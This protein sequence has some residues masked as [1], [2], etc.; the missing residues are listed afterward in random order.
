MKTNIIK[1]L[2]FSLVFVSCQDMFEP[3]NDNHSTYERVLR[4]PTFAEGL[5]MTAYSK[6]PTNGLSFNE[7]A[8]DDAVTNDKLSSY[9]RMATGE[10]SALFNPVNEWDRCNSAVMYL[11][12]F[13]NVIDSVVWKWTDNELNMLYSKRFYGEAYALKGLFRY[14]L[15][16][17]VGGKDAAGNLLGIPL[18]EDKSNFN[19][20]RASFEE[21]VKQ[22]YADF[23]KALGYLTMD[24]Y[25]NV[26][27]QDELPAGFSGVNITNYNEVFGIR[28]NQRI[29]GRIV[30]ALKARVAL[31]AASPAFSNNNP[32]LWE[33]TANLSGVVLQS[34]GGISGLDPNGHR[35]YDA[36]RV[37]AITL[38]QSGADQKEIIWRR[39]IV[40]SN[41]RE[42]NN[43]PPSLFG[44]ATVNP[45]HN[46]VESFPMASG[47]PID[48][49]ASGYNPNNPYAN[50]DPRL[51]MY[52]VCNGGQLSGKTIRTGE[53]AGQDGKD[54]IA[55]STRTGYYLKKLLRE[56]VNLNPVSTNTK[57]HFEVHMRYTELFLIYAE[58]AN[59]AWGPDGRGAFAFS[60]R[61]VIAALRKRA[62]IAQ[63]DTYLAS[64]SSK[65]DM[66]Q[67]IRNER[68]IE[69]CFEG[70]R[71]WDLRRWKLNLTEPAKGVNIK[72]NEITV[73]EVERRLYD[74]DYMHYGPI[75]ETEITKYN[76]LV[77]NQGW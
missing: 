27:T 6:I 22:I 50:R 45:T 39:A 18:Y 44:I 64:V 25:K 26:N 12:E 36:A 20:P 59:E 30:K 77:Q 9:L 13:I 75:P 14:H 28:V 31:L 49:P 66:R 61:E 52:I 71:F 68:R 41:D 15:L 37:D 21:S 11:N 76:A 5:L 16:Q 10:W 46:L 23:D 35:F 73:V 33:N 34:N 4:D 48:A 56:D 38:I 24:D 8:T 7:T 32:A 3:V 40:N 43:F 65:E 67:L 57:K 42:K 29:S 69:L 2:V 54:S 51:A 72:N 53:G 1:I 70:F 62:G 74:N 47:L 17:T 55:T 60:A 19:I 63:P 58:A